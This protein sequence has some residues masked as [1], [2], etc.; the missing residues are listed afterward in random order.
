VPAYIHDWP[1][2]ECGGRHALGLPDHRD[3]YRNRDFEYV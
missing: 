1:C 3:V 2:P